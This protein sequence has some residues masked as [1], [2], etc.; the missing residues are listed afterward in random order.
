MKDF[1]FLLLI[2]LSTCHN[3]AQTTKPLFEAKDFTDS[4]FS[5]G[6]E[7]PCYHQGYL[8]VVNLKQHGN[9]ARV[10]SNG[11]VQLFVQ[12]EKGRV[13]NGIQFNSKGKMMVADYKRHAV[14][15]IDVETRKVSVYAHDE[16]MNQPND[17]AI[18]AKDVIFAADPNW[19]DSTGMLWRIDTNGK[20]KL[21]EKNIGT[22]NGIALSPD[23]KKLYVNE[24]VQRNVWVYDVDSTSNLNNKKLFYK[25]DDFGMDGMHTDTS[26][27]LYIARYGKGTV[28]V[29]SPE[30]KL[31]REVLLKGK[32]PTNLS[33]GGKDGKTIYVTLQ[34][35][36]CIERFEND[37]PGKGYGK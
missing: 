1:I 12:L 3:K 23:D 6:I 28:V 26:G 17:L 19:H 5:I 11:K 21:L 8:Y 25:F 35:R 4:V 7:G 15:M 13:G 27:N 16:R 20:T 31:I 14:L 10:D 9:I 24:S 2:L 37:V 29:L 36:Q 33:F 30:G 32:T 22:T 18:S 34:D